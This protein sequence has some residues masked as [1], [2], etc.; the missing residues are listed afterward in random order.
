MNLFFKNLNNCINVSK[1]LK[2]KFQKKLINLLNDNYEAYREV[3][4]KTKKLLQ[5]NVNKFHFKRIKCWRLDG[6][7]F[8]ILQPLL[9]LF[10]LFLNERVSYLT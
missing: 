3:R 8:N 2:S 10:I 9:V 1:L 7:I 6:Y 5:S 4:P